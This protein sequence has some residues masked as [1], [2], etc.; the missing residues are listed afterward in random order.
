M[1]PVVSHCA[2]LEVSKKSGVACRRTPARRVDRARRAADVSPRTAQHA[3]QR[4][5][6]WAPVGRRWATAKADPA[7]RRL[8][9][10]SDTKLTKILIADS[11]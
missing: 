9:F 8:I 2:G 1:D 7:R 10:R 6:Q 11:L 3:A 5:V 4:L